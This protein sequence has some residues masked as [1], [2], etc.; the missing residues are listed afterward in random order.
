MCKSAY[1]KHSVKVQINVSKHVCIFTSAA[2]LQR[3]VCFPGG[4]SDVASV[5]SGGCSN[6][7]FLFYI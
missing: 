5:T 4:V 7:C 3:S 1:E 6:S 2:V